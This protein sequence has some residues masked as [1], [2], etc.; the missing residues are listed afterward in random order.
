MRRFER[1]SPWATASFHSKSVSQR[2]RPSAI[3]AAAAWP[4]D[5]SR[6][7]WP[8]AEATAFLFRIAEEETRVLWCECGARRMSFRS[9]LP[10]NG[11]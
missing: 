2:E 5:R 8:A 10:L 1:E 6:H 7:A 11:L 3:P 9:T 4:C